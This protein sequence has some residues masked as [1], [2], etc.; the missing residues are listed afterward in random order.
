[1]QLL[2]RNGTV[3]TLPS[4]QTYEDHHLVASPDSRYFASSGQ[5]AII[6]TPIVQGIAQVN[7]AISGPAGQLFGWLHTETLVYLNQ[8]NHVVADDL[9]QH[10]QQDLGA[11]PADDL[12]VDGGT[13]SPDRSVLVTTEVRASPASYLLLS[14]AGISPI[15]YGYTVLGWID[16]HTLLTY[17]LTNAGYTVTAIDGATGVVSPTHIQP[18]LQSQFYPA[19]GHWVVVDDD[20]NTL[21]LANI[22][23]G[24]TDAIAT[25][26]KPFLVTNVANTGTQYLFYNGEMYAITLPA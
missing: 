25:L 20:V 11:F 12:P 19:S 6:L 22:D 3:Q 23:T 14:A 10:T 21:S 8:H 4:T 13:V 1:M 15:S 26:S 24:Q 7:Q 17:H 5:G 18:S 2:T 16:S 9:I